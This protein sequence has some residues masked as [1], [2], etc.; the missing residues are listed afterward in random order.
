MRAFLLGA[1]LIA[2]GACAGDQDN[3]GDNNDPS[4]DGDT[5]GSGDGTPT[6]EAAR[7]YDGVASA[8]GASASMGELAAMVDMVAI[9]EGAMP[10]GVTY[11]GVDDAHF[12]HA[13][14]AR[15]GLT[16]DYLYH[17]NDS[18]DVIVPTCDGNA[19]HSHVTVKWTGNVAATKLTIDSIALE[20]DWAVRDLQVDKPRLGGDGKM[21]FVARIDDGTAATFKI[22]YDATLDRVRFAPGQRLPAAGKIDLVVAVDRTRGNATRTFTTSG[23]LLFTG[24]G[25]A[26]L[27]LDASNQYSL[28]LA[29]GV[30]TRR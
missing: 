19:N 4:G 9:A 18:A 15:G 21:S 29:T 28:D 17:C 12:H 8:I 26:N 24:A 2:S 16:F 13:T 22:S 27:T 30:T 1:A 11:V 23:S 20:G 6:D 10:Q 14:A 3:D 7:D 5:D 25:T